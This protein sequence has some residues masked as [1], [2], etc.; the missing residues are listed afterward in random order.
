[1]MWKASLVTSITCVVV[2]LGVFRIAREFGPE[3]TK[4]GLTYRRIVSIPVAHLAAGNVSGY[5]LKMDYD[6]LHISEVDDNAGFSIERRPCEE[7]EVRKNRDGSVSEYRIVLGDV[8][9]Y[10]LNGD[11]FIDSMEDRRPRVRRTW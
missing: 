1:M 3:W 4:D 7:F 9:Y 6:T 11:G 2:L 5:E 8:R 10:D